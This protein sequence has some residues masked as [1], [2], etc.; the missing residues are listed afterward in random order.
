MTDYD[1]Y[2]YYYYFSFGTK[3]E[4]N[5]TLLLTLVILVEK[6][7]RMRF[8]RANRKTS[9][10]DANRFR[11][12]K[13]C[14]T[15][16]LSWLRW[17]RVNLLLTCILHPPSSLQSACFC[18]SIVRSSISNR[19]RGYTPSPVRRSL[20]S[21]TIFYVPPSF[22]SPTPPHHHSLLCNRAACLFRLL[23]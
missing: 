13:S 12:K 22:K 14:R 9:R 8:S 23:L 20:P 4:K 10:S 18:I 19:S 16:W 6:I 11:S 7:K 5:T 17:L 1:Y 15:P 3:I 2:Y 21:P